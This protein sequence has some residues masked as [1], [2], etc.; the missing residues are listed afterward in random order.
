MTASNLQPTLTDHDEESGSAQHLLRVGDKISH[1]VIERELG[2]GG[3]G[4]VYLAKHA[5][6][7]VQV[8][9]KILP[10]A[11]AYGQ[12][13]AAARFLREARLAA[14][15]VHPHVIKMIDCGKDEK[16][17]IYYLVQE[18]V[19]GGSVKDQLS[20]GPIPQEQAR[21]WILQIAE[22]LQA[23]HL[24]KI[25]HRDIKPDNIL[26]TGDGEAK[27]AD[28]GLAKDLT[29]STAHL[30]QSNVGI[31]TPAY[32]S[33]EQIS[34]AKNVDVRSDIY[35]L[36][37][38]LF[39][40][41]T[42]RAPYLGASVINILNK[43]INTPVPDPLK[44]KPELNPNL[45]RVCMKMIQKD[46]EQRYQCPEELIRALV[47]D[48]SPKEFK[49]T[50]IEASVDPVPQKE[51]IQAQSPVT[52]GDKLAPIAVGALVV[53]V[54]TLV[55]AFY[56]LFGK[57][58][59]EIVKDPVALNDSSS[60]EKTKA[61]LDKSKAKP[62]AKVVIQKKTIDPKEKTTSE[63]EKQPIKLPENG[64][65]STLPGSLLQGLQLALSFDKQSQN[66][67]QIQ[68]S[69]NVI[70]DSLR[71]SARMNLDARALNSN[72]SGRQSVFLSS[73]GS[74][75]LSADFQTRT[76]AFWFKLNRPHTAV[77]LDSG[78][79]SESLKGLNLG[80][81][82]GTT[83]GRWERAGSGVFLGLW[84]HDFLIP[85]SDSSFLNRWV[86]VALAFDSRSI[87]V[88]VNGELPPG[89]SIA[90][91]A[92]GE[93]QM[94]KQPFSRPE[95]FDPQT[96]SGLRIGAPN[97]F[98]G[99]ILGRFRGSLDDIAVWNRTLTTA[100]L[101][102]LYQFSKDGQS[103]CEALEKLKP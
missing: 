76:M 64:P 90:P 36:G 66:G 25:I 32:M 100:E 22:A 1:Y 67:R 41:V 73:Q 20:K 58:S 13:D 11:L 42:G 29:S 6:V 59:P 68:V 91:G 82:G 74:P 95:N 78:M 62:E 37:A 34:D 9:I 27:L 21:E 5:S 51:T 24:K 54:L 40:M 10:P 81:F 18:F 102:T 103:Y 79:N 46:P 12:P 56:V 33:P 19:E 28:L 55:G 97:T 101:K 61:P 17:Q 71:Q 84:R 92:S 63:P 53:M 15:L 38:T 75:A 49:T 69:A 50:T 85:V 57:E 52:E 65:E 94:T 8:A 88:M 96:S 47:T 77:M 31:G 39:H 7:D 23:A 16:T 26:L 60:K 14:N 48:Q 93:D 45:A 83:Y 87:R 70:A 30:T 86:F 3:M 43:V 2:R 99:P 4:A 72:D 35:S 89:Y 80:V 44:L 98:Q